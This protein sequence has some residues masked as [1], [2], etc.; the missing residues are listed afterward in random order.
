LYVT[1]SNVQHACSMYCAV[2]S[3][4]ERAVFH[5]PLFGAEGGKKRDES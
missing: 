4:V 5:P 2:H 1:L 3:Y